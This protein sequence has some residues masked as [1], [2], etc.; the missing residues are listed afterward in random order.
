MSKISD[1]P[2]SLLFITFAFG[3]LDQGN[4][5]LGEST[6]RKLSSIL[7]EKVKLS[8]EIKISE[9]RNSL[10][11]LLTSD[12]KRQRFVINNKDVGKSEILDKF[13][14]MFETPEPILNK[15]K[16]AV[17]YVNEQFNLYLGYSKNFSKNLLALYDK[18]E[19]F[20]D[21]EKIQTDAEKSI[22]NL[23][24]DLKTLYEVHKKQSDELGKLRNEKI[25]YDYLRFANKFDVCERRTIEINRLLK[26][27]EGL[28]SGKS[29]RSSKILDLG[30]EIRDTIYQSKELF[31]G[32]QYKDFSIRFREVLKLI[33]NLSS[34][35]KIDLNL[36]SSIFS[37]FKDL[38]DDIDQRSN[39]MSDE[40]YKE[41]EELN[42]LIQIMSIFSKY[43]HINPEIPGSGKKISEI[44]SPMQDRISKLK[45]LDA[46]NDITNLIG[47]KCLEIQSLLGKLT[48]EVK[49][50]KLEPPEP[51]NN[52]QTH[53]IEGLKK[54]KEKLVKEMDTIT[55]ELSK[56]EEE[57]ND[58]PEEERDKS[59]LSGQSSIKYEEISSSLKEI[60]E[61]IA[62]KEIALTNQKAIISQH[63]N[64]K[65]PETS[66][67]M[68]KIKLLQSRV[69]KIIENL[70]SFG[71]K[72]KALNIDL[73]GVD[74]EDESYDDFYSKIGEY[75]A[76]IVGFIYAKR[77]SVA[78]KKIDFLKNEYIPL[79]SS[80]PIKFNQIGEG[81]SAL[82][83]IRAKLNQ[84]FGGKK[85]VLLVD[86]IGNMDK[87]NQ[88][89]LIDE[90]REHLESGDVI[91]A[92]LT[93]PEN[94]TKEVTFEP[95]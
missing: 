77:K 69:S 76:S 9:P 34:E 88:Q 40:N 89:I 84:D 68:D 83:S 86:E 57:Y 33:V 6:K 45:T 41:R 26:N 61:Q 95:L 28:G 32:I 78:I 7:D 66:L 52:K 63:H 70:E 55:I 14:V 94:G 37:F 67:D 15:L 3:A 18:L 58:I 56:I 2:T 30:N 85:K 38:T 39:K 13:I 75:L 92:L 22:K 87:D 79:D 43:I 80:E 5:L 42:L 36:I 53:D 59:D 24:S 31:L 47:E 8:Y 65:K 81:F 64:R 1:L 90:I 12:G 25:V 73:A 71:R 82:N 60:K 72:L 50:I 46:D 62:K 19:Y 44:L 10:S 21:G 27:F 4:N 35:D 11:L 29:G 91:L 51:D 49:N 74:M 93:I 20:Q 48:P 23:E 54:E 17:A 16:N